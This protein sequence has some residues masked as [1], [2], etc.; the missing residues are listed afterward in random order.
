MEEEILSSIKLRP[1]IS[2]IADELLTDKIKDAIQDIKDFINY[3]DIETIPNGCISVVKELVVI[4]CNRLGSEGI[5]SE[6]NSGVSQS[7]ID[8]IPKELKKKL[9]RYRK[10]VW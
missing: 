7:Y 5:S 10:L 4:R 1:G 3:S 8:G 9:Y 6:S 2:N